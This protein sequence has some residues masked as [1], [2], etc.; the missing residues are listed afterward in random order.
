MWLSSKIKIILEIFYSL[1][2]CTFFL[3]SVGIFF[4]IKPIRPDIGDLQDRYRP[5]EPD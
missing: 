3:S 5:M 1:P 4:T 2:N